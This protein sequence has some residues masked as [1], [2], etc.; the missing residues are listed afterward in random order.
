MSPNES[1]LPSSIK[2]IQALEADAWFGEPEEAHSDAVAEILQ[3]LRLDEASIAAARQLHSTLSK[4]ALVKQLGQ[5][6]ATLLIGYRGLRQAQAKLILLKK[7][8]SAEFR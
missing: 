2:P 6:A 1:V 3:T 8:T 4:E 5:D 7:L